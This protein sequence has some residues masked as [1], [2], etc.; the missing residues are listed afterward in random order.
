MDS[1]EYIVGLDIGT[2][3]I[4]VLVGRKNE[5]QKIEIVGIGKS[6]SHGVMRGVVSN[7][8]KTVD[9]IKKAVRE[10]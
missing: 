4:C 10:A 2:T 9:A 5:H 7:I 1:Q 8:D 3:K 6:D